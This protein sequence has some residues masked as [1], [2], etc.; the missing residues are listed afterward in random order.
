MKD[1]SW[2][3]FLLGAV[4]LSVI[5]ALVSLRVDEGLRRMLIAVAGALPFLAVV[6]WAVLRRL[7]SNERK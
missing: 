3:A 7:T 6:L 1:N 4:V 5:L 2:R